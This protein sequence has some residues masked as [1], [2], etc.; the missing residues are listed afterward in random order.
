MM[1]ETQPRAPAARLE[2]YSS[3]T[4]YLIQL[5]SS[6]VPVVPSE[7]FQSGV[8]NCVSAISLVD[9]DQFM[10][11]VSV[12]E[13]CDS[14]VTQVRDDEVKQQERW[15]QCSFDWNLNMSLWL[16]GVKGQSDLLGAS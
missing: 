16:D 9:A 4:V 14:Q 15:T 3:H 13:P 2:V 10:P 7:T 12:C 1:L 5:S 6:F 11:E 8:G